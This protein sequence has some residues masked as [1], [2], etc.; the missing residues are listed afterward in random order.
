MVQNAVYATALRNDPWFSLRNENSSDNV[1]AITNFWNTLMRIAHH[2]RGW[3]CQDWPL[4]GLLSVYSWRPFALS[5]HGHIAF[6]D[7]GMYRHL[8]QSLNRP[9][10][11]RPRAQTNMPVR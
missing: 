5:A 10:G 4:G 6:T 11:S 1:E 2:P 3:P 8:A 9:G 7:F